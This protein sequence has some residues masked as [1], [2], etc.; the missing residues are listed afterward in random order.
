MN[1]A[2]K[3]VIKTRKKETCFAGSTLAH[4]L[5]LLWN[6][7][8]TRAVLVEL[9]PYSKV[10]IGLIFWKRLCTVEV[11]VHEKLEYKRELLQFQWKMS[12]SRGRRVMLGGRWLNGN[13]FTICIVWSFAHFILCWCK[14]R[15]FLSLFFFITGYFLIIQEQRRGKS[16]RWKIAGSQPWNWITNRVKVTIFIHSVIISF[17]GGRW[18]ELKIE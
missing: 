5:S 16:E 4:S 7:E 8:R 15:P 6:I 3:F 18:E 17:P 2:E 13:L 11:V 12:S 10:M 1:L 9:R 14:F